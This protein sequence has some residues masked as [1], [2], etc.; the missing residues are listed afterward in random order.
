MECVA[1]DERKGICGSMGKIKLKGIEGIN[2]SKD[3]MIPT[4]KGIARGVI[5][6]GHEI[7]HVLSVNVRYGVCMYPI[8]T[9]AFMAQSVTIEEKEGGKE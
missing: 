9:V 7:P 8:V 2:V 6:N 3:V 5:V 1:M 4:E